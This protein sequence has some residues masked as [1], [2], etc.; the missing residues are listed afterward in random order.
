MLCAASIDELHFVDLILPVPM[1]TGAAQWDTCSSV[2]TV[3]NETIAQAWFA[4]T[5]AGACG[6]VSVS[7]FHN[8]LTI[9]ILEPTTV[10]A[11]ELTCSSPHELDR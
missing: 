2:H 3:D 7:L 10:V 1:D 4:R 6:C 9:A 8:W 11:A 5:C